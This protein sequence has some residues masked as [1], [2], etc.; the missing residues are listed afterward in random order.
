MQTNYSS[1]SRSVSSPLAMFT[2]VAKVKLAAAGFAAFAPFIAVSAHAQG[3]DVESYPNG[4]I[5][6]IVGI[7]AGSNTDALGRLASTYLSD[8]MDVSTLTA[9]V[10]MRSDWGL[11]ATASMCH[12]GSSL[13]PHELETPPWNLP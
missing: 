10:G 3:A 1:A 8:G 12:S 6:V 7:G 2:K 4:P 5:R 11:A 9:I 13:T